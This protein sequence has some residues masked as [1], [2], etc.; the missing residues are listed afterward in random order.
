[1]FDGNLNSLTYINVGVEEDHPDVIQHHQVC[2]Q[3]GAVG[4]FAGAAQQRCL[5]G[6]VTTL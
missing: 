5:I 4:T 1:M 3:G 6:S 2:P